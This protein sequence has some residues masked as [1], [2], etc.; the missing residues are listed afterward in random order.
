V[1]EPGIGVKGVLGPYS[2]PAV[3]PLVTLKPQPSSVLLPISSVTCSP[4]FFYKD[5]PKCLKI[6]V[7]TNPYPRSWSLAVFAILEI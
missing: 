7:K 4:T 1:E 3:P 5:T 6:E 2:D